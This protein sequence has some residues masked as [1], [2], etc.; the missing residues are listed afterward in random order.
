MHAAAL[1]R[2]AADEGAAYEAERVVLVEVEQE[3][4]LS[5]HGTLKRTAV[6]ASAS[7]HV[8]V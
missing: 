6:H 8:H 4:H 1:A 3:E 7:V 2:I 5:I